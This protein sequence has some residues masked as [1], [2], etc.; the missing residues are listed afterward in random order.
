MRC[1]G[2]RDQPLTGRA[3]S[4]TLTAFRLTETEQGLSRWQSPRGDLVDGIGTA[5]VVWNSRRLR[6]SDDGVWRLEGE[7][8]QWLAILSAGAAERSIVLDDGRLFLC[9]REIGGYEICGPQR[10]GPYARWTLQGETWHGEPQVAATEM[11]GLQRLMLMSALAIVT[12]AG[13]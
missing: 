4:D 1:H 2:R 6:R 9:C 12:D 11:S 3:V 13:R 5:D 7:G 10:C 8:G